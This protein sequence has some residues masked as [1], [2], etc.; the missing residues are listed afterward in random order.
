MN[1]A[2]SPDTTNYIGNAQGNSFG[3]R[4]ETLTSGAGVGGGGLH[5]VLE[6]VTFTPQIID[7]PLQ[8]N[9][10]PP[11]NTSTYSFVDAAG[12]KWSYPT[13]RSYVKANENFRQISGQPGLTESP[14][15]RG[16]SG[17][18]TVLQLQPYPPMG[19]PAIVRC[20][21]TYSLRIRRC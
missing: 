10:L 16:Y 18:T 15:E 12:P 19:P 14:N 4:I 2:I 5:W 13:L 7:G 1:T 3:C 11:N 6:Y 20:F 8:P 9:I 17:P 21:T